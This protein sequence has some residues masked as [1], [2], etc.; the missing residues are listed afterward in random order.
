VGDD[1]ITSKPRVAGPVDLARA[2]R[3]EQRH[4]LVVADAHTELQRQTRLIRARPFDA[5]APRTAGES[6]RR[7][8]FHAAAAVKAVEMSRLIQDLR[9]ALRSFAR[10]PGFTAVAVIVLA[11]GIGANSA[12]FTVV[13]ALLFRPTPTEGEGIVG[14]FRSERTK[15]D[16]YRAFAYP[17]YLE[18]RDHNDVF[19]SLA[20]HTFS[21]AGVPAGDTQRRIFV[22]LISANYFDTLRVPLAAG[23]AFLPEEERPGADAAVVIVGY[24]TWAATG[25]DRG[26]IGTTMKINGL[27]HTI[28]G[29]A[30]P[31]FGGTM[32]LV[33][34]EVWLPLGMFD[35]IVTDMFKR[36]G[37]GLA[38]VQAGSVTVIGRLRAGVSMDAASAR[39]DQIA[40]QLGEANPTNRDQALTIAKLPRMVNSTRP[41][42]DAGL[43][44]AAA[45][46][47]G[48]AGTILLIAC[49]NLANM[50]MARGTIRKKEIAI[51]LALGGARK[52]IIRQLLTESLLLAALG[53]AAGLVIA[54][55]STSFLV[56][57][58]ARVLPL[59]LVFE[60]KPDLNVLLA[61]VGFVGFATLLAGVGPALKLSRLDLVSDLK[62]QAAEASARPGALSPRNLLVVAQLALSLGLL[63]MGGL[64]A[65]AALAAASSDPGFS[66]ERAILAAIDTSVAQIDE[67][68]TR[69]IFR[70]LLQH[71]RALPGVEAASFA[72]TVPFGNFHEG[73]LVERPGMPRDEND[74]GPTY[75]IIGADYFKALGLRMIRGREFTAAE[76][77]N[78]GGPRVSII[79]DVLAARLFPNEDPV[80]QT[81]RFV[82]SPSDPNADR[83]PML[84][85]GVAP[86]MKEEL[87]SKGAVPHVYVPY[88]R[89]FR[90]GMN[91]HVRT[92]HGD[93]VS[94]AAMLDTLRR[95]FRAADARLPVLEL[96]TFRRFHE[97]SLELWA[98]NT[99][100]RMFMLFGLLAL[101]LAVAG[102]YGVRSY[103]VSRRTSEFG[104]RMALGARPGDLTRLVMRES[105]GLTLAGLA[106]GLPLAFGAGKLLA[107]VI[108]D[109][110]P[111]DPFVFIVA[112]LTLAGAAMVAS[113]IPARKAG[114][115]DPLSA[116]RTQ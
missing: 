112:P 72:S 4:D 69:E 90:S 82:G 10:A 87:M 77:E 73:Q 85:V 11:L 16:S 54:Y 46:L 70:R 78:A 74:H 60:A 22:E 105:T 8:N 58:L 96:T 93:D 91:L 35:V 24:D 66:Y 39:L 33:S 113:Y 30:P 37:D 56:G 23:R 115:V 107:A 36:T 15:P 43:G 76:E 50:L 95:E 14:L 19:D 47:M 109:V 21:M 100:G 114:R 40:R 38:D 12:T 111:F 45:G 79:D 31:G 103:L 7:R 6:L 71:V 68:R 26:F 3:A 86:T 98:L 52:R 88:G 75:R 116:L 41:Q 28:V 42:T 51:R 106:C 104:I 57:S 17:N 9:F 59:T 49:L 89:N 13:N 80:G 61:T 20:A 44:I 97:N 101:G 94:M 65:R 25:F 32:A 18:V 29:V 81:I 53:A 92:A 67:T 108:Y 99:A 110:S 27:D 5:V 64:F 2:A 48:I 1:D 84:I 62:A 102:V 34:P 55:W 83:E 63:S